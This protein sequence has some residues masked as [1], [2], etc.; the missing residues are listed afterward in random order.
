MDY[1]Q[2]GAV[3]HKAYCMPSMQK[4]NVDEMNAKMGYHVMNTSTKY[5]GNSKDK[6]SY[7]NI[8]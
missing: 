2:N 8:K 3:Q 5:S 6:F 4:S 7:Q 1:K